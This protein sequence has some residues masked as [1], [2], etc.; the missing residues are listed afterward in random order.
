MWCRCYRHGYHLHHL[1][2]SF[3]RSIASLD[4]G[5][6]ADSRGIVLLEL[7]CHAE[8]E[9]VFFAGL[10]LFE[11]FNGAELER[12]YSPAKR[13]LVLKRHVEEFIAGED[14]LCDLLGKVCNLDFLRIYLGLSPCQ[15]RQK[16]GYDYCCCL[17]H[18]V[19]VCQDAKLS[20]K[21]VYL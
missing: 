13:D 11:L 1:V 12:R 21:D 5:K 6:I 20:K 8:K 17:F 9:V 10:V 4:E 2:Y 16:Y 19:Y 15:N 3:L 18:C 7:S 14:H